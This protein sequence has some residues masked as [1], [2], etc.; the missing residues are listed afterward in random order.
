MLRILDYKKGVEGGKNESL[1]PRYYLIQLEVW[2]SA[3]HMS[4][5]ESKSSLTVV[6][7]FTQK[8]RLTWHTHV[9]GSVY[10]C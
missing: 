7:T 10:F 5:E 2:F 8:Y 9:D 4:A 3:T 1:Y 6:T